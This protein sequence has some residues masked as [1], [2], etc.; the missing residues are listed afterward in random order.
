M[1][2][3][4]EKD[5]KNW[6]EINKVSMTKFKQAK[7]LLLA[8]TTLYT[9]V[10]RNAIQMALCAP[11]YHYA[12]YDCMVQKKEGAAFTKDSSFFLNTNANFDDQDSMCLNATKSTVRNIPSRKTNLP[13]TACSTITSQS[14]PSLS[15]ICQVP[16]Y[17]GKLKIDN[18]DRSISGKLYCAGE[19]C[20]KTDVKTCC[21]V[22]VDNNGFYKFESGKNCDANGRDQITSQTECVNAARGLGY[23]T[24]IKPQN[25]ASDPQG[26]YYDSVSNKLT[27]NSYTGTSTKSCTSNEICFCGSGTTANDN[28]V[29]SEFTSKKDC[30][31]NG[32]VKISSSTECTAAA[33]ARGKSA[34][35]STY[36]AGNDNKNTM[37]GPKGCYY[38]STKG[39]ILNK[40]DGNMPNDCSATQKCYCKDT[41]TGGRRRLAASYTETKDGTTYQSQIVK[42]IEAA[43]P[44]CYEGD[45]M[46]MT[47]LSVVVLF[48]FS[49]YFPFL[50]N[51]V[52]NF[53]KPKP[54]S[55]DD[56]GKKII[57]KIEEKNNYVNNGS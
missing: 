22:E 11:K 19:T 28:N 37:L 33:R 57:Q 40:Y 2:S 31:A 20:A 34:S 43:Y 24:T 8:L 6:K 9:P 41:G 4:A 36:K 16:G 56:P 7:Y 26:C 35:D 44:R 18:D 5:K 25:V 1:L 50:M 39:L 21:A 17:T 32:K 14:T 3:K 13:K 23:S 47:I 38:D 51:K 53:E 27:Y 55:P 12:K 54:L 29:Y 15:D 42:V 49:L 10:T 46:Y 30:A 52:I 48:A 45:H